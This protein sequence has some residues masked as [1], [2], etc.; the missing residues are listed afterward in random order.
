[1][2][3]NEIEQVKL[4]TLKATVHTVEDTLGNALISMQFLLLNS[5]PD[6]PLN[7]RAQSRLLGIID[8]ALDQLDA[9]RRVKVVSEKPLIEDVYYLDIN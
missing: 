3:M 9:M 2:T 1:M 5:D 7:A 8:E 6:H 4:R